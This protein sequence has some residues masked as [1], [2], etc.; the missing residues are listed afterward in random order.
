MAGGSLTLLVDAFQKAPPI[1]QRLICWVL[2]ANRGNIAYLANP[3]PG[4]MG[5][6]V[7]EED[8]N[9]ALVLKRGGTNLVAGYVAGTHI[10]L[11]V[12]NGDAIAQGAV[13]A[14]PAST[15]QPTTTGSPSVV[16]NVG[17]NPRTITLNYAN[18]GGAGLVNIFWGDGTSTLGA[19]E[20]GAANHTYPDVGVWTIQVVD[21]TDAT[22]VAE[23]S[24]K[25]G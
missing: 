3:A 4:K 9:G 24:V 23:L 7:R 22:Q 6:R 10:T 17:G 2:A 15:N 14:C 20:S 21:A 13:P 16:L 1:A 5:F 8:F 12:S 11:D 25:I 19:A 18:F